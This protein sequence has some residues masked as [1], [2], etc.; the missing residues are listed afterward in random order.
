[1]IHK[2]NVKIAES[3]NPLKRCRTQLLTAGSAPTG[4]ETIQSDLVS[5][6]CEINELDHS[7][8]WYNWSKPDQDGDIIRVADIGIVDVIRML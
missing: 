3:W 1:M 2:T 7:G 6:S 8:R 4:N 5:A